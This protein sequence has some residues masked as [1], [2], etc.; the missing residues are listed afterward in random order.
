MQFLTLQYDLLKAIGHGTSFPVFS[1][2]VPRTDRLVACHGIIEILFFTS[3]LEFHT[4]LAFWHWFTVILHNE[5]VNEGMQ[6]KG[7]TN[8]TL[9]LSVLMV[10]YSSHIYHGLQMSRYANSSL[11]YIHVCSALDSIMLHTFVT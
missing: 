7:T 9:K 11:L 3:L 6:D 1:R 2:Y 8:I 4:L 10:L 5:S